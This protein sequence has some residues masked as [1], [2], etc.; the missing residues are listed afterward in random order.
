MAGICAAIRVPPPLGLTI[1]M[2]PVERGEAVGQTTQAAAGTRVRATD[3][4]VVDLDAQVI[5]EPPDAHD[6][7][8]RLARTS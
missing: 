4:V 6:R 2:R 8:R 5:A 3:P 1:V 7:S